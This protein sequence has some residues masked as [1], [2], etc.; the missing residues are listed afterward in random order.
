V[1]AKYQS[2][3][4]ALIWDYIHYAFGDEVARGA[5]RHRVFTDDGKE[6][7]QHK[8]LCDIFGY[9]ERQLSA[10]SKGTSDKLGLP[11]VQQVVVN[12]TYVEG[13][14]Y[15]RAPDAVVTYVTEGEGDRHFG[16]FI[17]LS[18]TLIFYRYFCTR[19]ALTVVTTR[20]E[21]DAF[22]MFEALNTTGEPLTAY[23]TFRP[24]VIEAE[25]LELYE[26]S[27]SYGAI[28][29]IDRYLDTFK[30]ADDRQRATSDMLIPYALGETGDKLQKNLS[31]QRRYLR[32]SFDRLETLVEQRIAVSS[33]AH[34]AAFMQTG[35]TVPLDEAPAIE[36]T[37][38]LDEITGFAFQ[39]LR[40]LKHNITI[41][42]LLYLVEYPS[43]RHLC[44]M[45]KG[46][47]A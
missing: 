22:D 40:H 32:D 10:V 8:P 35:W 17:Q 12:A 13:L 15:S 37:E 46:I 36:G 5:F 30:K 1:Q 24:K 14:W 11:S 44:K 7:Q 18:R 45:S 2:P 6:N 38:A 42:A 9:I 27:P 25:G 16:S 20:T 33:M 34:L 47:K 19:V 26:S 43:C 41:A 39:A 28:R 29:R 23:E 31:A 3:I 4:A 21:D